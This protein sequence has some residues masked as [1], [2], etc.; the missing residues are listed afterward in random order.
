M[1][2]ED[3]ELL[4]KNYGGL[5]MKYAILCYESGDIIDVFNTCAEAVE[6]LRE[7]EKSDMDEGIYEA[8]FYE[9]KKMEE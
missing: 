2:Q 8:G 7:Y 5:S 6:A 3:R 4:L 9:I 1:T